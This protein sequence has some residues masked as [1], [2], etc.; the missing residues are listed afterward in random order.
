M[1]QIGIFIFAYLQIRLEGGRLKLHINLGAGESEYSSPRGILL[2]D[3]KWHSITI[4]RREAN[5]TMKV[6]YHRLLIHN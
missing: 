3:T 6:E 1:K 4:I 2:N 5:L